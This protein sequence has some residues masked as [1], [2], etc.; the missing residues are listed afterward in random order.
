MVRRA[1]GYNVGDFCGLR[2]GVT[3]PLLSGL[4]GVPQCLGRPPPPQGV[5]WTMLEFGTKWLT[6]RNSKFYYSRPPQLV[7]CE[8]L[9]NCW[10]LPQCSIYL[11]GI[12]K[13]YLASI[14]WPHK[15][16]FLFSCPGKL[17]HILLYFCGELFYF[18]IV[19]V[20]LSFCKIFLS[21]RS[22][23][24][25]M[26]FQSCFSCLMTDLLQLLPLL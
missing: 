9:S 7:W 19:I 13:H 15:L 14:F 3:D 18:L 21:L 10:M 20:K 16:P 12:K 26:D 24:N 8:W 22:L 6:Y 2:N 1:W 5:I 4:S 11:F 17:L 23:W 25:W